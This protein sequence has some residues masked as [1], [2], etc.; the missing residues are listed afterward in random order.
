MQVQAI[1]FDFDGVIIDSTSVK[2]EAFVDTYDDCSPEVREYVR[3]YHEEN[4][5]CPRRQKIEHFASY[6]GENLQGDVDRRIDRFA[7]LVFS[8]VKA[9]CLFDGAVEALQ[10]L[11]VNRRLFVASATPHEELSETLDLK[12]L[13]PFFESAWGF[14]LR[15]AE[16]IQMVRE[17]HHLETDEVVMIGDSAADHGAAMEAGVPFIGVSFDGTPHPFPESLPVVESFSGLL[18]RLR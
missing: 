2:T 3:R 13:T 15:K 18:E 6:L 16:A 11:Q 4:Q 17:R 12:G 5:G 9:C 10:E 8:K 14:P 7:D 1:V